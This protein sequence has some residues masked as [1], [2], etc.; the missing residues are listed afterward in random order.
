MPP[1][2]EWYR[3]RSSIAE[4][5]TAVWPAYRG[6]RLVQVG[7]NRQ[8]AFALY[9]L[10]SDGRWNAHSIQLLAL[11]QSGIA[12]LTMYMQPL[13]QRLFSAFQLPTVLES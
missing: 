12:A 13:A 1:W 3:S 9:S 11:D 6:F 5:F 2:R 10:G 4:F 8:P 7:A